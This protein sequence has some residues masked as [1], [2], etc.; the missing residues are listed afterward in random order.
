MKNMIT[1]E[2]GISH[3]ITKAELIVLQHYLKKAYEDDIIGEGNK[4]VDTG[5]LMKSEE[6][7][8]FSELGKATVS[9]YSL[10]YE[11]LD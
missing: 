3:E 11:A 2:I 9:L 6:Y 5:T 1:F 4:I 7:Q 8:K 10:F